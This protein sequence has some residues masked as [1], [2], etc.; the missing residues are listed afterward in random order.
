MPTLT[1]SQL[2]QQLDGEVAGDGSIQL[3]GFTTP[4]RAKAGDLVFAENETYLAL[5]EQSG[6]SAI[7]VPQQ[8]TSAK[9][10]L[11]RVKNPRV[12]YARVLPLFFPEPQPAPG[13]HPS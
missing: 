7:L 13:I 9:K 2:A 4:D 10:T 5:A 1:A 12:A 11:I 8:F 3:S 6:A